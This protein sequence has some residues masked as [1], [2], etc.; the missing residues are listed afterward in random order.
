MWPLV[1]LGV[2]GLGALYFTNKAAQQGA[3]PPPPSPSP[4]LPAIPGVVTPGIPAAP[5]P[6]AP[7]VVPVPVVPVAPSYDK[8]QV[9]TH[10]PE[11]IG[12]LVIR[13][14]PSDSASQIGGAEKDGIVQ[15]VSWSAGPAYAQVIWPGGPRLGPVSGYA[16]VAYLKKV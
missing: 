5:A 2:V 16:H 8:A 9:T 11:P 14:A 7:G 10:D 3:A 1:I 4:P 6:V 15:V 13:S 12:D